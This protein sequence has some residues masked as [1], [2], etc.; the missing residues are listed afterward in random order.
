[1]AIIAG[2]HQTLYESVSSITPFTLLDYPGHSACILWFSGCNLRCP[3]CHNPELV[4]GPHP[5][6]DPGEIAAFLEL[7]HG[8]L[9]GVTLSGGECTLCPNI[10]AICRELKRFGFLVKIDSNGCRP[11]ILTELIERRL[12]D[13]IALDY[14]APL[15][16]FEQVARRDLFAAFERSLD[17]IVHSDIECEIRT[18]THSHLLDEE[19]INAI[20]DDLEQR[21]YRKRY[22]IQNFN[23]TEKPTLGILPQHKPLDRSLIRKPNT[24]E[25]AYRNFDASN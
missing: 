25:V 11:E 9:E 13:Y 23:E 6:V 17:Q 21:G 19:A 20:I 4:R 15:Q 16:R 2:S 5:R 24:F 10:V 12:I 18:T 7:R 22:Y 1:M 3:Y 8:L 14:K